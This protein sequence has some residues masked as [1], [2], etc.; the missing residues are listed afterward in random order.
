MFSDTELGQQCEEAAGEGLLACYDTCDGPDDSICMSTCLRQYDQ[1]MNNCPC[2]GGCP[3]GCPCPTYQ[4][5]GDNLDSVL[6]L[7]KGTR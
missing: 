5:P 4:C 3:N 2:N 6:I 1:T 7:R